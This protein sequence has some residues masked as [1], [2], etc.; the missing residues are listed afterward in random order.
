MIES[1]VAAA[2]PSPAMVI[3]LARGMR[4]SI[5]ATATPVVVTAALKALR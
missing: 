5:F 2:S 4:V 1:D 3:E